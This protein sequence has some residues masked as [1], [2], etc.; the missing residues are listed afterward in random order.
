VN[1]IEKNLTFTSWDTA[2]YEKT[3]YIRW[4]SILHIY[5]I[6]AIKAGFLRKQKGIWI[7]TT[8]GEEAMLLGPKGLLE[9][10]NEAYKV[11]REKTKDTE[12]E[13]EQKETPL[14][15]QS[16]KVNLELFQEQAL[17]GLQE[18]TDI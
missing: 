5:T 8:E 4:Q 7:L 1:Q 11:W 14:G 12:M 10:A 9:K 16:Q 3:G 18:Y 13:V 6:D 2:R 15:V 17:S